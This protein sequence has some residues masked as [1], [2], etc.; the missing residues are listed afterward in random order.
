MSTVIL[1]ITFTPTRELKTISSDTESVPPATRQAI[2]AMEPLFT[3]RAALGIPN[4]TV[5]MR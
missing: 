4:S 1:S 2:R 3:L 5:R